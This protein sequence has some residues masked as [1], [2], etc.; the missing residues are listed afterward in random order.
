VQ[1]NEISF[2]IENV[3]QVFV[4]VYDNQGR[5]LRELAPGMKLQLGRHHFFW[6]RLER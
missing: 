2:R 1:R 6:D 4:A 5:T 3:G